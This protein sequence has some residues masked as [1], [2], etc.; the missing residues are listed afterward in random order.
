MT[1]QTT[2]LVISDG[3]K[4]LEHALE[5]ELYGVPH[6]RGIF[7]KIKNLADHLQFADLVL[8]PVCPES[9][10]IHKAK[11][12]RKKAILADASHVYASDVEVEIRARAV[13]F[14]TQWEACEPQA[15][16]NFFTDFDKTLCYLEVDLPRSCVSLIRT[17]NLLERFHKEVR[18][19]Q[20]DIGMFQSERGCEVLWYLAAMR[21][22]A[23]Q[24]AALQSRL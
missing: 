17:T 21:E 7:H 5:R 12:A 3:A 20:R 24:R 9:K 14:R 22:T 1:E 11:L 18:R 13:T 6:Q 8:E 10:A 23:K 2:Q 16:A 15:V 19:K 4:G